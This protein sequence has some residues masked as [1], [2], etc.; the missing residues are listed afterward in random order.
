M[1]KSVKRVVQGAPAV[2]GAGVKLVRILGLKTV[3]DFDPFLMLDSFDSRH[4]KDYILGFPMHPHRGIETITYLLEGEINH[5]DSLGNQGKI[6]SG[7][8]QW[9]TAG[10]GIL[11]TEMP[12][13]KERMLGLQLWLNLPKKDKM[14]SP[15]YFDI[16]KELIKI[17]EEKDAAIRVISGKYKDTEGVQ[18]HHI[19]ATLLDVALKNNR[20]ITIP[21]IGNQTV[22]VFLLI[23]DVNIQHKT[24]H[25]KSALLFGEGD[26]VKISAANEADARFLFLEAEPLHE[27]VAW[28]GPIVM[29]TDEEL[30]AAFNELRKGTFIK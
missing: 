24:Y 18:P 7:G 19:Q 12:Q 3:Q 22:F 15:K 1:E 16:P 27:A 21:T 8:M 9:M 25:E 28:G 26:F 11:H 6:R 2:D 5:R 30:Y 14:A 10:S 29:N 20:E 13:A 17:V 4:P 23:G